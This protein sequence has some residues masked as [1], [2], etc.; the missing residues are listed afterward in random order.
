MLSKQWRWVLVLAVLA[1]L[2]VP[3]AAQQRGGGGGGGF[4][5]G[6]GMGG[7]GGFRNMTPEQRAEMEQRMLERQTERLKQDLGVTD[8]EWAVLSAPI[9]GILKLQ[10]EERTAGNELRQAVSA[11]GATSEQIS[12]ALAT[13]RAKVKEIAQKRAAFQAQLKPL[14]TVKQEAML[15][16]SDILE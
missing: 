5:G 12:A 4:G 7:R 3:L 2:V 1:L 15:V 16:A 8:E 13:Y 6:R 14:V 10:M 11:E 9:E